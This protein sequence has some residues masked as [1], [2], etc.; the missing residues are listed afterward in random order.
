MLAIAKFCAKLT[1]VQREIVER[2]YKKVSLSINSIEVLSD[3]S[4]T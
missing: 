4:V 3:H 2:E 1:I